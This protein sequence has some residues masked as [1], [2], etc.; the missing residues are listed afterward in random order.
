MS[1][2][3]SVISFESLG[4]VAAILALIR[5]YIHRKWQ[6]LANLNIPHDKPSILNIGNLASVFSKGM[7]NRNLKQKKKYGLIYGEY[8]GVTPLITIHDLE[9]IRQIYTKEFQNFPDRMSVLVT[10]NGREMNQG[11]VFA[12]NKEWKRMRSTLTPSFTM[13]KLKQ[14]FS[15]VENCTGQ[16]VAVLEGKLKDESGEFI[17]RKL[18]SNLSL[19]MI[20]SAALG[21][22]AHIQSVDGK[23]SQLVLEVRK[24]FATGFAGPTAFMCFICPPFERICNKLDISI[25]DYKALQYISNF[26]NVVIERRKRGQEEVAKDL[27]QLM[28]DAEVADDKINEDSERGLNRQELIGNAMLMIGAGFENTANT[29]TFLAYNLAL[30]QDI[31]D[32]LRK[33]MDEAFQA[34]GG[35]DYESVNNMKYLSMC[36]NESLRLYMPIVV[37]SRVCRKETTVNGFTIPKGVTVQFPVFGLA[38]DPEFWD[39]PWEFIPDRME[40]MSQ[41]DPMVFQP[42]GA[43]PRNCIGLRFAEMEIKMAFC[44]ILHKFKIMP[45]EDTPKP[46]LELT[47]AL[48]VRPIKEFKLKVVARD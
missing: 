34:K 14:M 5:Y 19:D 46:P 42:F 16:T 33:E 28:L 31:Q 35:F 44:Q 37:N 13:S 11:V 2:L 10:M 41:I 43:G 48:G 7:F 38:H 3:W 27:L 18:F 40:D 20:V 32:K 26:T 45:S 39:K 21:T 17:A 23:D 22:R 12:R 4:L 1:W 6:F 25:F 8:A 24:L 36:L 15:I 29:M 9:I 30:H 47:F